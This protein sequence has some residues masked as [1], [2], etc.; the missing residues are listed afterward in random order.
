M[1]KLLVVRG[2]PVVD[3]ILRNSG[4]IE[5][6]GNLSDVTYYFS[7]N[8]SQN[9][10]AYQHSEP[11]NF[12]VAPDAE[13]NGQM[14]FEFDLTN[15]KLAALTDGR[16]RLFFFARGEYKDTLE[17][18]Y[19]LPF[20]RLY[21]KDIVGN[22]IFCPDKIRFGDGV[23][24]EDRAWVGVEKVTARIV[25]GQHS[26]FSVIF[27]N[28][29]KSPAKQFHAVLNI[30]W[31]KAPAKPGFSYTEQMAEGY[32]TVLPQERVTV[33]FPGGPVLSH[34]DIQDLRTGKYLIYASGTA[35]YEDI[36]GY[37]HK[38]DY[39][40]LLEPDLNAFSIC[41]FHNDID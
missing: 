31:I 22:L 8:P 30:V 9:S 37:R 36:S 23:R 39:C 5:A 13:F 3:F 17:R 12:T 7:L 41:A 29:G 33:P 32:G 11:V 25:K 34:S 27:L 18:T 20:C 35:W 10:F 16:A 19:P 14:R 21:D 38:T 4:D 26:D 1:T 6:T 40:F 2:R 15:E 28:T 24:A